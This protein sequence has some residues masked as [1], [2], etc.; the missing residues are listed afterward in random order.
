M[1][2]SS[3]TIELRRNIVCHRFTDSM[4][5]LDLVHR[6]WF[7]LN[8]LETAVIDCLDTPR[9][10]PELIVKLARMSKIGL[11][12][13]EVNLQSVFRRLTQDYGLINISGI[14]E[15]GGVMD[16][17][18]YIQNPDVNIREEDDEGALL[19]NPDTD[20]V[21]LVNRTGL[22]I[23]MFLSESRSVKEIVTRLSETFSEV[24][25][26]E[27]TDH[28]EG[29]LKQMIDSGFIGE[30]GGIGEQKP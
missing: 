14:L 21:Q 1:A 27:V 8:A 20:R 29:F 10:Y 26:S 18:K 23:W 2:E 7:N 5:V 30:I 6:R 13:D 24:S 19:F 17:K 28:V 16:E 3:T 15:G 22:E 25:E 11:K 9:R 4:I 12:F